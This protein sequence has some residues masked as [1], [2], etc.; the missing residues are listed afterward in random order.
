M[1]VLSVD[2][3]HKPDILALNAVSAALALSPIPWKGPIGAIRVGHSKDAGYI[4]NPTSPELEASAL[5]LVVSQT[6]GKTHMVEA[7]STQVTEDIFVEA[8]KKAHVEKIGRASCR[9]RV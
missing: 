9:E 8:T 7:G 6:I 4:L 3:V 2:L 1:T 5:D